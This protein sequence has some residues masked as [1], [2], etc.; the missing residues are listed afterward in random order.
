MGQPLIL[1]CKGL[2]YRNRK[3][4]KSVRWINPDHLTI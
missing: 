3:Q 4:Y 1:N 2:I